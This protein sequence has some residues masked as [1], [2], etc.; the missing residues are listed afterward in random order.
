MPY[1][2]L[3]S[4]YMRSPSAPKKKKEN[5]YRNNRALC[6]AAVVRGNVLKSAFTGQYPEKKSKT[7]YSSVLNMFLKKI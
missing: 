5:L 7:I 6:E 1:I 3:S 4:G 2:L